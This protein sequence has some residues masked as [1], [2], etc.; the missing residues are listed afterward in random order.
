MKTRSVSVWQLKKKN[1]GSTSL[2]FEM[3]NFV[4]VFADSCLTI[5]VVWWFWLQMQQ[6]EGD[7]T[8][9]DLANGQFWNYNCFAFENWAYCSK[10]F[11]VSVTSNMMQELEIMV[12]D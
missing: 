4:L 3:M 7:S 12:Q 10:G 8:T 1:K 6:D 9:S 5:S 2:F 11:D